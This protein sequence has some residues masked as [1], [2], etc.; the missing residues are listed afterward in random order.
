MT[1]SLP[2]GMIQMDSF[3]IL[4]PSPSRAPRHE[5]ARSGPRFSIRCAGCHRRARALPDRLHPDGKR[6][7]PERDIQEGGRLRVGN[8]LG[9]QSS[10][11]RILR[12]RSENER[13]DY[14]EGPRRRD[15]LIRHRGPRSESSG[16]A[17][18]W[19]LSCDILPRPSPIWR[20][21]PVRGEE[22]FPKRTGGANG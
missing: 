16:S 13:L 18:S 17:M 14:R 6:P 21:R 1:N 22:T 20:R 12:P 4:E 10:S 5:V 2:S 15:P 3:W 9:P 7:R 11:V 8:P 19:D